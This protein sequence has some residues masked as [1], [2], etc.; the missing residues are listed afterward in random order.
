MI[1]KRSKVLSLFLTEVIRWYMTDNNCTWT[2]TII[3]IHDGV[4]DHVYDELEQ[5]ILQQ[6]LTGSLRY[7]IFYYYLHEGTVR[8]KELIFHNNFQQLETIASYPAQ[9]YDPQTFYLFQTIYRSRS[10]QDPQ[11]KTAADPERAWSRT[12]L[13]A[14]KHRDGSIRM[15]TAEQLAAT[16]SAEHR[17]SGCIDSRELLYPITGNRLYAQKR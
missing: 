12:G 11:P 2:V 7:V 17:Q 9:L 1:S 14:E 13:F 8:I 16:I 5:S 4:H 10:A 15:F 3:V 6:E